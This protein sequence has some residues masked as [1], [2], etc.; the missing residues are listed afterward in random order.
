MWINLVALSFR[1]WKLAPLGSSTP[2]CLFKLLS[3][4]F[5]GN[6]CWSFECS[7]LAKPHANMSCCLP[8]IIFNQESKCCYK[9]GVFVALFNTSSHIG[10]IKLPMLL[11]Y[12][13]SWCFVFWKVRKSSICGRFCSSLK[14]KSSKVGKYVTRDPLCTPWKVLVSQTIAPLGMVR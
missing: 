7:N 3:P 13:R 8:L 5:I 10:S 14:N 1:L 2:L 6:K 12:W 11:V 9:V 4:R